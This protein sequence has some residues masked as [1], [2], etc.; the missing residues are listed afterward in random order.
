MRKLGRYLRLLSAVAAVAACA[1][2][3]AQTSPPDDSPRFDIRRFVFDGAT[4]VPAARLEAQTQGFVGPRRSFADVQRALEAV[5]RAYSDAGWSAVQVVL[6]EQELDRGE[7]RFQVIEARIGRVVVEGNRFFDESNI[8]ASVPALVPGKAPNVK[9]IG[10]NLR[11][12]NESPAKQAQV[13]LR[14]GQEEATVDAVLR[15]V[16]EDP[17]KYSVTV[18]NSGSR[19]TG[20]LRIGFGYQNANT[21]GNDDVV[22]LQYVTAPYDD[23]IGESGYPE[24]LSLLPSRKVTILGAG[25]RIPLYGSGDSLDFSVGY[26]NVDSGVVANLFSISGAG[27]LANARYTKHLD[28]RGDYD[29]RLAFTA[30]WRSY[31]NRGVRAVGSAEQLIPDVTLRPIGIT[32]FGSIRQQN[33]ESGFSLGYFTNLSGGNDGTAADFCKPLLRNNGIGDCATSTYEI[34]RWSGQHVQALPSD[35]QMRWAIS[36]QYTEDL[37]VPGEMF[38]I[39]GADSVR[40]F[41]ERE[42]ADDSGHRWTAE[43]YTPDFASVTGIA[44]ARMRALVFI[45]G[46]HVKRNRPGPGELH[47]QGIGSWGV[48]LRFS[49]GSDLAFRLDYGIVAD[50]GAGRTR[51]AT[52]LH[53]SFSYIF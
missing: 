30:E 20:R 50:P 29:H 27:T 8:R 14:S 5:E 6:P 15:V 24:R 51:D 43:V 28:Q 22:T 11:V 16:D 53:A 33:S 4:L 26:S 44:G 3:F 2:A 12:A 41:Y 13:L 9:A 25:Y 34:W 48:G 21:T 17:S 37:L 49:R 38:G 42:I 47:S 10:R 36:A 35:F 23:Y 52:M 32:Y 1:P 40:G 31:D 19:Q 45:D 46:A 39:G 7:V 18:D